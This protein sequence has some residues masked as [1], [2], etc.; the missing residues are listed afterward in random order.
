MSELSAQPFRSEYEINPREIMRGEICKVNSGPV[1][2]L[3]RWKKTPAGNK[4]TGCVFEFGAHRL[5][6]VA[7]LLSDIQQE[8][9]GVTDAST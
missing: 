2:R 8:L 5:S 6:T 7:S 1:V 3:S 4:R 9:V